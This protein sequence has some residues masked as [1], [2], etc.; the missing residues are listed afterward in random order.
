MIKTKM[1][2]PTRIA[3]LLEKVQNED[4]K[5]PVLEELKTLVTAIHKDKLRSVA[6][7]IFYDVFFECLI[8]HS[9]YVGFLDYRSD[10][11][12]TKQILLLCQ[13]K[14]SEF[15][16]VSISFLKCVYFLTAN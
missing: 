13:H 16:D 5:V 14:Y 3:V 7:E 11:K 15:I 12:M 10:V 2:A 4:N 8:T 9:R 1:A 6:N